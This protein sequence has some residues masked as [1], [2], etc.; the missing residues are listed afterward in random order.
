LSIG[1]CWPLSILGVSSAPVAAARLPRLTTIA[2]WAKTHYAR[3]VTCQKEYHTTNRDAT[4][5]SAVLARYLRTI[6]AGTSL[7]HTSC[8][9]NSMRNATVLE[10]PTSATPAKKESRRREHGEG[11][12]YKRGR[13]W[14]V[15]YYVDGEQVRE[16][17]KSELKTVA[18]DM[19]QD[20]LVAARAGEL[21]PVKVTYTVV[22]DLLYKVFEQQKNKSLLT[23][24]D[25]AQYIGPVPA[26]D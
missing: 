19:L 17:S 21:A 25:G 1:R 26:L 11:R 2:L 5:C 4:G 12:V 9:E 16:S 23:R 13:T 24:K 6:G 18:L 3:R 22:R 14:W 8:R 10:M 7:T 15:Q 20:R